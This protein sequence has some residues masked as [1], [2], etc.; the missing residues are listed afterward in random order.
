LGGLGAEV[1]ETW[2]RCASRGGKVACVNVRA[3]VC[4]RAKKKKKKEKTTKLRQMKV[5]LGEGG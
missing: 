4:A 3:C 1:K 2:D 5:C